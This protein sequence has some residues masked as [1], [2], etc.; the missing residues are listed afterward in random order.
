MYTG[1]QL[2]YRR[3]HLIYHVDQVKHRRVQLNYFAGSKNPSESPTKLV[4]KGS[5]KPSEGQT[6][7]R[8]V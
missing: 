4:R 3:V 7:L 2:N 1:E 8:R 6:N 5:T